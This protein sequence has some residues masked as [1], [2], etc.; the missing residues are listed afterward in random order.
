M[1]AKLGLTEADDVTGA[2]ID[3]WLTLLHEH[4]VDYT[5]SFRALS[6]SLRGDAAPTR[7]LFS[8]PST[9]DA[10][11]NRWRDQLTHERSDPDEIASAMDRVN[12]LYVP[13]NHKVEEALGAATAGDLEPF[14]RLLDVLT[15]P[16]DERPGLESYAAP[17]PSTFG[18]YRTF[19]GT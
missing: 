18:P 5:S 15:H 6:A 4:S 10:W 11:A 14:Q 8:Q 9:F 19:C 1:R 16:F 3:G 2:L 7:S 17:A 12:P 13:R